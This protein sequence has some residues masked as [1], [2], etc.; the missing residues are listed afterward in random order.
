[1]EIVKCSTR[2]WMSRRV[3]RF[4]S[5]G[6]RRSTHAKNESRR[7]LSHVTTTT[8]VMTTVR[9]VKN[10]I[11]ARFELLFMLMKT[12]E[13]ECGQALKQGRAPDEPVG[14]AAS[15]TRPA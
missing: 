7:R 6:Y 9:R 12:N 11:R 2:C 1:M 8:A 10:R 3:W 14:R 5:P 4:S 15:R 13:E